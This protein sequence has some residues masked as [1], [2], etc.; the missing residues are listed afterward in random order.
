MPEST[1]EELG[2]VVMRTVK[3]EYYKPNR[4]RR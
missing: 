4:A 2:Q 1:P 3:V